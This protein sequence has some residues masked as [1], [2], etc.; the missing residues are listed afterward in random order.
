MGLLRCCLGA[1]VG[2]GLRRPRILCLWSPICFQSVECLQLALR[3]DLFPSRWQPSFSV[4]RWGVS[5]LS[6]WAGGGELGPICEGCVHESRDLLKGYLNTKAFWK[7]VIKITKIVA[8]TVATICWN[9]EL[10]R[11]WLV[12]TNSL[13][14]SV[15]LR[16]S[17][18]SWGNQG[19]QI[20]PGS[21]RHA[22]HAQLHSS[23][24]LFCTC[25]MLHHSQKLSWHCGRPGRWIQLSHHGLPWNSMDVPSQFPRTGEISALYQVVKIK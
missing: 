9:I 12:C 21:Y 22:S 19:M 15:I 13:V 6:R 4:P 11:G 14:L 1:A 3:F 25:I 7:T 18:A 24:T 23:I 2:Q 16:Y 17:I 8:Q 5:Y 10:Q 20:K